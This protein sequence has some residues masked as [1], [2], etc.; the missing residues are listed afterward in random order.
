MQQYTHTIS[1]NHSPTRK[2]RNICNLTR[3]MDNSG[4]AYI[5]LNYFY[6]NKTHWRFIYN[7]Y[8]DLINNLRY[9]HLCLFSNNNIC[10]YRLKRRLKCFG[11]EL[12]KRKIFRDGHSPSLGP[13]PLGERHIP[14][15]N[16]TLLAAKIGLP[17]FHFEMLAGM[18]K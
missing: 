2:S 9:I 12:K 14:S 16:F 3:P 1:Q 13:S 10:N 8:I 7:S 18:L 5:L 17:I 4:L 6:M 15:L 11:Y